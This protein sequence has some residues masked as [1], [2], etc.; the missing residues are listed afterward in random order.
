MKKRLSTLLRSWASSL[1]P[2]PK[3]VKVDRPIEINLCEYEPKRIAIGTEIDR[4][5]LD[6][7]L[8]RLISLGRGDMRDEII[9]SYIQDAKLWVKKCIIKTIE[10]SDLIKYDIDTEN[11]TV[12]GE[13]KIWVKS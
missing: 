8:Q 13:L 3:P 10:D 11:M 7:R 12:M 4:N 6:E 2:E 5:V 9:N 1:Y